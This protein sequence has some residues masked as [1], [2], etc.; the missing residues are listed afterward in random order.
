MAAYFL[1]GKMSNKF[2]FL[3]N[4]SNLAESVVGLS[5]IAIGIVGIKEAVDTEIIKEDAPVDIDKNDKSLVAIFANGM[6]HG[7]SWDG[8]PSLAPALAMTSWGSALS[9]LFSYC[10]GTML[11]MS[12][13]AGMVGEGSS[14]LGKV[15]NNPNL[16]RSLS[17][18][19][20]VIAILIGLFWV[21][22][23][24]C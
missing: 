18:I 22:Q 21:I 24:F 15:A 10:L 9:F 5:L 4:L 16:P 7:F 12:V 2:K 3:Q 8:T 1:K 19:S 13:T 20:S 17:M 11:T 14:R 23:A 6:L